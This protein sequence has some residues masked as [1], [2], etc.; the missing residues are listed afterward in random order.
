MP[1]SIPNSINSGPTLTLKKLVE[2]PKNEDSHFRDPFPT[3]HSY[4]ITDNFVVFTVED[5]SEICRTFRLG[6]RRSPWRGPLDC[7]FLFCAQCGSKVC[8][9]R[10]SCKG[11]FLC[12]SVTIFRGIFGQVRASYIARE[13]PWDFWSFYKFLVRSFS[14]KKNHGDAQLVRITA[15]SRV[16][17][18]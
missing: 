8:P 17:Q 5:E 14:N 3:K 9:I 1:C 13:E 2:T 11:V 4:N 16:E 6:R 7:P 12:P 10:R 15:D 18:L